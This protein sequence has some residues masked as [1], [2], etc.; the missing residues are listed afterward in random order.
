MDR[1]LGQDDGVTDAV[2]WA[3]EV[4]AEQGTTVLGVE[5]VHRRAWSTVWRVRT[6]AAADVD[7]D[8]DAVA[9]GAASGDLFLKT[10]PAGVSPEPALLEVLA[11]HGVPHVQRPVAVEGAHVLLPDG[12]PLVRTAPDRDARWLEVMRHYAEVQWATEPAAAED[13]VRAGVPDLRLSVLPDAAAEVVARWVP[14]RPGFVPVLRDLAAELDELLPMATLEHGDLHD[15]NAFA[16]GAVP[17]DWGDACVSHP[18]LSLLVAGQQEVPGAMAAYL[19]TFFDEP[20]AAEDPDV[21]HIVGLATRLAVV[22]RALSWQRAIDAAGDA[23]PSEYQ[24][25]P[26]DWLL[27]LGA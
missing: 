10:A 14:E 20:G 15:G 2:A 6:D 21:Q 8:A 4:L 23:V 9:G 27:K 1:D 19:D 22:P 16:A 24:A 17:F 26:R 12:G 7:A 25:A 11:L 5:E 13:L 18:F 3:R